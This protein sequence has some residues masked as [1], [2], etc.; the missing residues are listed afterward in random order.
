ME[1]S[2]W[3][4]EEVRP[5]ESSLR[6]YLHHA[7]PS[8]PDVD[9]LVQESYLRIWK[10]RAGRPVASAKAFLF[11]VARHI[12]IDGLRRRRISPVNVVTDLAALRVIE[13]GPGVAESA[14][15]H[16]EIAVLADAIDSLPARC[17]EI[18]ILRKLRGVPQKAIAAQLGLSEQTVQ[19]QVS[20]GVKRIAKFL[21]RRGVR[22]PTSLSD[23]A[24]S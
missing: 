14:C 13:E 22:S 7:Y 18:V 2:R 12:A 24:Q 1:S 3:F 15:R 9:D 21:A 6:S 10:A 17:R 23:E 19:V 20:R 8:L 4:L 11:R 16:E 5:H